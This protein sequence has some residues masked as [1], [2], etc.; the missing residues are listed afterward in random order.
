MI[1]RLGGAGFM[2]KK[3]KKKGTRIKL[4]TRAQTNELTQEVFRFPFFFDEYDS[5]DGA[6][7]KERIAEEEENWSYW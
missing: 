5:Y 2:M 6:G 4:Q 7:C 1:S 3:T